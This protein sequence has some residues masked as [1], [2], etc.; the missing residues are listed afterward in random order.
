[1]RARFRC[2]VLSLAEVPIPASPKS[3]VWSPIVSSDAVQANGGPANQRRKAFSLP[4]DGAARF[5]RLR[6]T[7]P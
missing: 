6:I 7:G 1:M 2:F 5:R 3:R 4:M